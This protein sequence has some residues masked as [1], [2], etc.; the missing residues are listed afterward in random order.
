MAVTTVAFEVKGM[1]CEGCESSVSNAVGQLPGVIKVVASHT[2]DQIDVDFASEP[3]EEAVR[4][5]VEDAG[6]DFVGRR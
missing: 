3:N 6:F 1:T 5:A 2:A 4:S